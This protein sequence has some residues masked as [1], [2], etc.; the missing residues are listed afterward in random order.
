MKD[1]RINEILTCVER[2]FENLS[3]SNVKLSDIGEIF[4]KFL[5]IIAVLVTFVF[6]FFYVVFSEKTSGMFYAIVAAYVAIIALIVTTT[7][8]RER[9]L[10]ET[11]LFH[12][13]RKIQE[14]YSNDEL[15]EKEY[16]FIKSLIMMKQMHPEI[17]LCELYNFDESIFTADTLLSFLY[18]EG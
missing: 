10:I 11:E 15:F 2:N 8:T 4:F 16:P 12:N 7:E 3:L 5:E 6:L 14:L 18:G 17:S 1:R 9:L 13:L